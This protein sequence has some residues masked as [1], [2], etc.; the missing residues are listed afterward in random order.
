MRWR[1]NNETRQRLLADQAER[2]ESFV[3][4]FQGLMGRTLLPVGEGL[5]IVPCNSIH[6]FFM[7]IAIDVA[8]LDKEGRVVKQMAALPPWRATSVY[9]RA[10]SVLELPAGVLTASGT[11]EGDLLSF[12]PVRPSTE[13]GGAG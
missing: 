11:Q 12:E 1:V 9:F 3:Q 7:R 4:R 6:T 2:A 5:H 13:G 10:H 8:F